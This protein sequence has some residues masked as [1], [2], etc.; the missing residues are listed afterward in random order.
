MVFI[1]KDVRQNTVLLKM[2]DQYIV[3]VLST[4][5]ERLF[6]V[7]KE[8]EWKGRLK[9]FFPNFFTCIQVQDEFSIT[10]SQVLSEYGFQEI[11]L[12]HKP[13]SPRT[14]ISV[15]NGY[16]QKRVTKN[17]AYKTSR[18]WQE[19]EVSFKIESVSMWIHNIKNGNGYK[20]L[21]SFQVYSP[22]IEN[23][24][25]DLG[26]DLSNVYYNMH[27]TVSEKILE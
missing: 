5:E 22:M 17:R 24:R 23:M 20:L 4:C 16:E 2:T 7:V 11:A 18:R 14:H 21:C 26:C 19:C 12:L 6:Q 8:L 10:C 1:E 3:E 13:N 9:M 27:M 25:V 15:M